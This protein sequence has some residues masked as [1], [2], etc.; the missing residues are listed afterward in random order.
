MAIGAVPEKEADAFADLNDRIDKV[1]VIE[2]QNDVV[3]DPAYFSRERGQ[4]G[5][6]G[7]AVSVFHK[8]C[9]L[10]SRAGTVLF[11]RPDQVGEEDPGV[12]V[13]GVESVPTD[14]C[15]SILIGE[16]YQE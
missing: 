5:G 1:P 10:A 6:K 12:L 14:R 11:D 2:E 4:D 3:W 16:V 7:R 15:S 9:G 8:E 13:E